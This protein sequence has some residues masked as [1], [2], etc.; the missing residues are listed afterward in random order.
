VA[1]RVV[2]F[3]RARPIG[4]TDEELE[5]ASDRPT[6]VSFTLQHFGWMTHNGVIVIVES[7]CGREST[8]IA[9]NWP[10]YVTFSAMVA[11]IVTN[12]GDKRLGFVC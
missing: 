9:R 10:R 12:N 4:G 5:R 6:N 8:T 11:P 3:G 2:R 1:Q 7:G